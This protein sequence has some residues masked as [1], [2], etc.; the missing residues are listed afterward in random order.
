[1]SIDN[2][3]I[4]PSKGFNPLTHQP[5]KF[6][7][8]GKEKTETYIPPNKRYNILAEKDNIRIPWQ[9]NIN[10]IST[11]MTRTKLLERRKKDRIPDISYDL[12]NDG[13]VGGKDFVLSKLYDIDGDGK[14]NETERK[15][16]LE[17]IKKGI[18]NKYLWNLDNQGGKRAFRIL[19]KRGAI[20]DAEDFTPVTK[21]YPI[22]P[23][24]KI[25]PKNGIKTKTELDE[26]RKKESIKVINENIEKWH[27]N[28]PNNVIQETI[29]YCSDYK[30]LYSSMQEKKDKEHRLARLKIGLDEYESEIKENKPFSLNYNKNP[31]HR[32]YTEVVQSRHKENIEKG[33]SI[34]NKKHKNEIERMNERENEIFCK[35][36]HNVPGLTYSEI[37]KKRRQDI[38]DYNTKHFSL[39]PIG[40]H[41]HELPKFSANEDTKEFW[42]LKEGYCENPK[43]TSQHEYKENIKYW[44][45]PE[46]LYLS[47]HKEYDPDK[48]NIKKEYTKKEIKDDI[49]LKVNEIN[50]Y[51][52]FDPNLVKIPK[53]DFGS[54]LHIYRWTTLVNQFAP[55]KFKKGRMFDV[56]E[57]KE[58]NKNIEEELMKLK[59]EKMNKEKEKNEIKEKTPEE[60]GIFKQPLF[61]KFQSKDDIKL[62]KSTTVKSQGF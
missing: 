60:L 55:S 62:N 21:T 29:N 57:A 30:P 51:N 5:P 43:F 11:P 25:Q 19:Q 50:F 24:S 46:D 48:D 52:N 26:F 32:T 17:G 6:D 37:K 20:I 3:N 22:H 34:Y 31:K 15:N 41:G 58:D 53:F 45:K 33:E 47:E 54:K 49:S 9:T 38:L 28:H 59:R 39:K 61:Q 14:L 4:S 18:E 23:L 56:I 2:S 36:Y 40:V 10:S 8:Y 44:K 13:Y 42:K 12:D 27:K 16:A 1:M 7:I 35:L